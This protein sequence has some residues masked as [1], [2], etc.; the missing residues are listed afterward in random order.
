MHE[1]DPLMFIAMGLFWIGYGIFLWRKNKNADQWTSVPGVIAESSI[2][3]IGLNFARGLRFNLRYEYSVNNKTFTGTQ[4]TFSD[5]MNYPNNQK[6][7]QTLE[8]LI[9]EYPAGKTV[10]V[11]FDP[12]DPSKSFRTKGYGTV[13]FVCMFIGAIIVVYGALK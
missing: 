6:N 13:P 11:Y 3:D 1:S 9:A 2:S 8:K 7:R 5:S 12:N 10:Q 4:L